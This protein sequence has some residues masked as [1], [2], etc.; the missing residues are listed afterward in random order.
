MSLYPW[1]K[2]RF[3]DRALR[4]VRDQLLSLIKPDSSLLDVG[5]GTGAMLFDAADRLSFGLGVDSDYRMTNWATKRKTRRQLDQLEFLNIDA[6]ALKD[7]F[8]LRFDI[9]TATLCLHA[10]PVPVAVDTL[11][12]M[13]READQVWIADYGPISSKPGR[14][15]IEFDELVSGHY[16]RFWAWRALGGMPGLTARAGL[17]IQAQQATPIAGLYLWR[18]SRIPPV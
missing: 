16:R 4:P 17:Y 3:S 6:L 12:M 11:L 2:S 14:V 13:S 10:M 5:C 18:I 9:A 1:F 15:M 8:D 7:Y